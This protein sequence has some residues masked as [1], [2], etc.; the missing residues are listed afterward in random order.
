MAKKKRK[1]GGFLDLLN[2]FLSLLVL[3]IL[4]VIGVALY[5]LSQFYA[6]GPVAE[7][8]E[9]LVESGNSLSTVAGRLAEQGIIDSRELFWLG[10][11]ALGKQGDLKAGSFKVPAGASMADIL[12][13]FTEG[14]PVQYAVTIPEGWTSW[15]VAERLN[16]DSH[17][18]AGTVNLPAE[19]TILPG[20]YDYV[21]GSTRQS[22]LD[23]MQTAMKETVAEVWASCDTTLC[24]PEQTIKTPEELVILA[25]I[26]ERETGIPTEREQVAAVF[27]NRL[28]TGMR[29]QSDPTIIYGI[30]RGQATLGRGLKKSEIEAVND[31]NTYQMDGLPKGPIANPGIESL[32]AAAHPDDAE[33]LYFV[34]K[35]A[36]PSD[37]HLFASSY[38][39][40]QQNV[41]K[42]RAAVEAQELAAE[43]EADA[44]R[45]AILAEEAAEAGEE[46]TPE[47]PAE[48]TPVEETAPQ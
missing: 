26:I 45:E 33:Y 43:A 2:G 28:K 5:G 40:H 41:A 36:T 29:L 48:E 8:T 39:E 27:V 6:P 16:Q 4:V 19:G 37:G 44:T 35:T 42:Y 18:L 1:R 7:D 47:T 30:T 14:D 17:R 23:D 9:F 21:P 13:E 20:T 25:S 22:V 31:Y 32:Q 46:V 12:K 15:Q 3:A 38:A 10:A 11:I 34:A 24:G